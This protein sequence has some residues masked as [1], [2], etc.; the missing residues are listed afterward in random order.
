MLE[1]AGIPL[2]RVGGGPPPSRDEIAR[3]VTTVKGD[4]RGRE[5]EALCAFVLAWSQ[6]WPRSFAEAFAPHDDVIVQWAAEQFDDPNR[7]LKLRRIAL[8]NLA[9]VL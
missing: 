6:G 1:R 7:Y 5:R 4:A 3:A 2:S 8:A 9:T